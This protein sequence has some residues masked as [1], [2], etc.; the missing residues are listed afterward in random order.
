[1]D[2]VSRNDPTNISSHCW[3]DH[4]PRLWGYRDGETLPAGHHRGVLSKIVSKSQ[5][6]QQDQ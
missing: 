2:S 3:F 4:L 1:M 5:T 6:A